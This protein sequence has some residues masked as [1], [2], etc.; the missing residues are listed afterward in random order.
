VLYPLPGNALSVY[1]FN[2]ILQEHFAI[3]QS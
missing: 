2:N 3:N 1:Y